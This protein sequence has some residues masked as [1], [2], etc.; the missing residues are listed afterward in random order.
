MKMYGKER[1]ELI[2]GLKSADEVD[3]RICD[4]LFDD[5]AAFVGFSDVSGVAEN[6]GYRSCVTI[7]FK[8]FDGI[9]KGIAGAPTYEY[10]HHYRTVNAALDGMAL[11]VA[12]Y[13]NSQGFESIGIPASQSSDRDPFHGAFAHKTGARLCGAGVIGKNAL[14]LSR[15]FGAKVRLASVLTDKAFDFSRALCD[16]DCGDCDICK[17]ACPAGA[18]YGKNYVPGDDVSVLVDVAKCSAH[19]K[20]AYRDI[21][22]GAVC[23]VCIA[24]CPRS[25]LKGYAA[26]LLN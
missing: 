8:L 21:G 2:Y 14:F 1:A 25:N 17:R 12:A 6:H 10:F 22:R 18:I 4:M 23:G 24:E 7:G 26:S 9:L 5:G 3:A 11:R 16:G 19:M 13:L 20:S 15:D